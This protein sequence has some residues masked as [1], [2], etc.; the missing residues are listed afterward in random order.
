MEGTEEGGGLNSLKPAPPRLSISSQQT[1]R[2]CALS[3]LRNSH[4]SGTSISPR[5]P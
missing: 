4:V 3:S 1:T 2:R 5:G